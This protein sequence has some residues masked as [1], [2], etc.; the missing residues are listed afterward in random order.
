MEI[1]LS[2]AIR[3]NNIAS[4]LLVISELDSNAAPAAPPERIALHEVVVSAFHSVERAATAKKIRID[5]AASAS[6]LGHRLSLPP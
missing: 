2:H 1:I 6:L 4:D 5:L 3:L